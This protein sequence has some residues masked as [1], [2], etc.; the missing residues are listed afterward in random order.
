MSNATYTYSET[1]GFECRWS[2]NQRSISNLPHRYW[3]SVDITLHKL[4][5]STETRPLCETEATPHT[6]LE[7]LVGPGEEIGNAKFGF[8]AVSEFLL[9]FLSAVIS[10]PAGRWKAAKLVIPRVPGYIV[11]SDIIPLRMI[12]CLH[13]V[14]VVSFSE[15]LQWF[16]GDSL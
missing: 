9:K 3:L 5:R 7:A 11:R 15:P 14:S 8:S 12:D 10:T 4:P 13:V 16:Q 2:L 1:D 6:L